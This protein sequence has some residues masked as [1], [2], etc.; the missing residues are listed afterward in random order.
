MAEEY[1]RENMPGYYIKTVPGDGLCIIYAF[2]ECL[3]SIG[4]GHSFNDVV[5]SLREELQKDIYNAVYNPS[6]NGVDLVQELDGYLENPL[7]KYDSQV[8][9]IY[10]EALGMAYKVNIVIFQSNCEKC[11][12]LENI[13]AANSF[14]HTIYFVRTESLHFD[15]VV[16]IL[17]DTKTDDDGSDSDDS[18]AITD[19]PTDKKELRNAKIDN[20]FEID[21]THQKPVYPLKG[22]TNILISPQNQEYPPDFSIRNPSAASLFQALLV[23]PSKFEV[24]TPL[25]QVRQ[26]R[27]YTVKNCLL[28]DITTDDNGAYHESNRN[29]R[30]YYVEVD[31]NGVNKV[32]TLNDN[33][34]K[35]P[36]YKERVGR[37]Y[38]DVFVSTDDVYKLSRYYRFS[39]SIPGLKMMVVTTE[40]Y[41]GKKCPYFCVVYSLDDDTEDEVKE[42]RCLPPHGNSKQPTE[43]SQP[44][45][46]T[47]SA[48]LMDIDEK[49]DKLTSPS[50]VFYDVLVDK[51]G[52]MH[53]TSQ[54]NE[55]RNTKQVINRKSLKTRQTKKENPPTTFSVTL[56]DLD[57]LLRAQRDPNSPVRTVIAWRDSYMAF[58]YTDKMLRDLEL[59]CCDEYDKE[60]C[61]LGVDSTFGL[62]DMWITDTSYRNKRLLSARSRG[63]PVHLGPVMFHMSKDDETFRRFSM[64]IIAS[65]PNLINLRKIGVD[66]EAAIYNGFQ[67]AIP[68]LMQLYCVK[69]LQDRDKIAIDKLHKKTNLSNEVRASYKNEILWDVYGKR[70]GMTFETGIADAADSDEFNSRLSALKPRWEKLCPGFFQWFL[71]HR[72]KDFERSA[73]KS[74]REGTNVA[75]LYYQNDVESIHASEKRIQLYKKSDVLEAVATIQ[76]LARREEYDEEMALYGGGNHVLSREYKTWFSAQWHSW[77]QARKDDYKMKFRNCKPSIEDSFTKPATVGR[78]PNQTKRARIGEPTDI[79]ERPSTTL[80]TLVTTSVPPTTTQCEGSEN[81]STSTI[82]PSNSS[83]QTGLSLSFEDPRLEAD[84]LF[85]LYAREDI[86]KLVKRCHGNCGRD[87]SQNKITKDGKKVFVVKSAGIQR[88]ISGGEPQSKPGPLYIHFKEECLKNYDTKNYYAPHEPFKW[89]QITVGAITKGK[90]QPDDIAFLTSLGIEL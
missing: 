86:P 84:T 38:K 11:R 29:S 12:I 4:F 56:G 82:P 45:V 75:G 39:K 87:I 67:S 26:D 89:R 59:F 21:F 48:V 60:A 73:I 5:V 77:N 32:A 7:A 10:L 64:E 25:K 22:D 13:N 15:P 6:L 66:M 17:C 71:T 80:P 40:S 70:C 44:Y 62:C 57:K 83:I 1:I 16:P 2:V 46:R 35:L 24:A 53:S 79:V 58:V 76:T 42:I 47:S 50:S 54:S 74:A 69:H 72:K 90:L 28:S 81:Q 55:P 30:L 43:F 41:D 9:D 3:Q 31:E 37:S 63:N 8:S 51:G 52:P 14:D 18:V 27:M 49:L 68:K 20:S 34:G 19:V 78:K 65:N 33:P 36:H 23:E 61:V 88:W 85:E